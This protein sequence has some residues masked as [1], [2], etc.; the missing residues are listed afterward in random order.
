VVGED[1]VAVPL[2]GTS[3]GRGE[4]EIGCIGAVSRQAIVF[5]LKSANRSI[6]FLDVAD[7]SP[8]LRRGDQVP[9][10]QHAVR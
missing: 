9:P 5:G 4:A 2:A 7:L 3:A 8:H 6:G 1:P 10:D